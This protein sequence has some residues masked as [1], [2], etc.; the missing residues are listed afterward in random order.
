MGAR[1]IAIMKL[2]AAP[3]VT[4]LVGDR[5]YPSVAPQGVVAPYLLVHKPGQIN[6]QL[7]DA[8][9]GWINARVSI[10]CIEYTALGA[11]RLG[12]AVYA[13]FR[14]VTNETVFDN[15]SPAAPIASVTILPADLDIDRVADDRQSFGRI[16]DFYFDFKPLD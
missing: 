7:L 6:R 8:D 9:A 10:E 14:D 1:Q 16:I 4:A 15:E 3:A 13:A 12:E 11:E 2:L 5:I